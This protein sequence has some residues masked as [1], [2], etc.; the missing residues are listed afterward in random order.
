MVKQVRSQWTKFSLLIKIFVSYCFNLHLL[1]KKERDR[2][3]ESEIG[4]VREKERAR[5]GS[6]RGMMAVVVCLC[7]LQF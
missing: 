7:V 3:I 4:R 1:E 6:S 2:E 5:P